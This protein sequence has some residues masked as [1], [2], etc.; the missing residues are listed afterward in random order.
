MEVIRYFIDHRRE[1]VTRRT[2]FE[3]KKAEA[4]AHILQGLK[5]ALDWLDAVIAL[6]RGSKNPA[7]AKEGLMAGSFSDP[8]YLAKLDA[9]EPSAV[10]R[11]VHLSELQAQ[12]ILEMRLHRLTGLERDK[13]IQEYEDI[14]RK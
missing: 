10:T 1:I 3:L 2:I 11:S 12:A 6:I 4:R 14:L 8:D 13:I 7:E 9:E 5:I